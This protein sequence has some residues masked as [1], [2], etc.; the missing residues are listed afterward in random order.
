MGFSIEFGEAKPDK[1]GVRRTSD[2]V[3]QPPLTLKT[4]ALSRSIGRGNTSDVRL[5]T[6]PDGREVAIKLPLPATLRQHDAAERFGNE[7][8]LTLQFRHPHVVRGFAGTPFGPGAF[9][10]LFYYPEGPLS[11]RLRGQPLPSG[12]A[13]RILADIASA[14]AYLHRLGAVH[15]DVKPQNVYVSEGR[16]ALGDLGSAYFVA[17][18]SKTSGSPYYMAPEVYHGESTSSASDVYSLGVMAWELLTGARP[19]AGNSYEEL[20]VAH[21]SRFPAPLA[22]LRPEL[23]RALCRLLDRT[24]AKRPHERPTADALRRALLEALGETPP[25]QDEET[26]AEAAP[27]VTQQAGRH[28]AAPRAAGPQSPSET[29]AQPGR[30][31]TARRGWNPFRRKG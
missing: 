26:A 22:S 20:M 5:A 24:F 21:L 12:E 17:Q 31:T 25:E 10:A 30:V 11:G 27:L 19:F 13:L 15:Q 8:R 4:Y 1:L 7:V 28:T 16:A 6:G 3:S 2:R 23:P 18:G 9:L 29:P 14:L